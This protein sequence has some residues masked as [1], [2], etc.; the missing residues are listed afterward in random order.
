VCSALPRPL[1]QESTYVLEV[2]QANTA[3]TI[4]VV[5]GVKERLMTWSSQGHVRFLV[6]ENCRSR[7]VTL[8]PWGRGVCSALVSRIS[9]V[10]DDDLRIHFLSGPPL[11]GRYGCDG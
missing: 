5:P 9:Y 10:W 1:T 7:S 8:A 6:G 2:D 11:R 4:R 3:S